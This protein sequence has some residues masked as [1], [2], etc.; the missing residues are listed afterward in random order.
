MAPLRLYDVLQPQSVRE[1]ETPSFCVTRYLRDDLK[2]S[3]DSATSVPTQLVLRCT[4]LIYVIPI[5]QIC[6]AENHL[7]SISKRVV[8]AADH[9]VH[10]FW[11]PSILW[12]YVIHHTT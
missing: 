8:P 4:G 10:C 7:G 11:H 6:P 9:L 3:L 2:T 1:N 5:G 12:D